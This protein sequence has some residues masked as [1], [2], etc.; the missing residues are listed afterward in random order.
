MW[1]RH[2]NEESKLNYMGLKQRFRIMIR[3]IYSVIGPFILCRRRIRSI[4]CID[5]CR[6]VWRR[7]LY[8]RNCRC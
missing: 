2:G 8:C 7:L 1:L 4:G 5:R 3:S 6:R